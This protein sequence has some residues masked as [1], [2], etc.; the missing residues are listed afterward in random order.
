MKLFN[1]IFKGKK[2]LVTGNTGFKGSWL[3]LWLLKLE[4]D[5]Y[6]LSNG[7][8]TSPSNFIVSQIRE[9]ITHF[10]ID[11]TNLD[12]VQNCINK[13]KPDFVFHLAAQAIVHESFINPVNTIITNAI[14]TAN[15]LEA[16]RR[17]PIKCVAIMVTSDKCYNN[18]EWVWGYK[19]TDLLGG[20]DPYSASKAAA[21]IIFK[22]YSES[23]FKGYSSR[24]RVASA[25]AGN[26]IGG[27]DWARY[28][29]IP[30]AVRAWSIGEELIIRSP[31]STRP[32]QHV[33]EPLSGYLLLAQKLFENENLNGE[34]FNFGPKHENNFTVEQLLIEMACHWSNVKWRIENSTEISNEAGLLKLNCDK[35]M[36]FLNWI[37]NLSFKDTIH[38]VAEWYK[39]Y[40]DNPEKEM[41][42]ITMK[43]IDYY[44]Q[45]AKIQ[46]L[47][48][49]I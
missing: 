45:S 17:L 29:I 39:F 35:S 46:K 16:L 23:Y 20:K 43:Q 9:K 36:H 6:G 1:E 21:E 13:I 41:F 14:G 47:I 3:S 42:S 49:T 38:L 11:I 10:D 40:Y 8:P 32:W 24:I 2:V 5:V 31:K 37:P 7:I 28:R 15:L 19:E 4:A 34:S 48:W 26:V 18:V 33:L 30:D 44:I 25:R 12:E 22:T 27:G